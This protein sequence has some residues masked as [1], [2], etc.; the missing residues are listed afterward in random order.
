M[1]TDTLV[2]V[3]T[4][5]LMLC[6]SL[7]IPAIVVAAVTGLAVSF[8][9]AITSLQDQSISSAVKLVAVVVTLFATGAWASSSILR[10][11]NEIITLAIPS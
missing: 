7:S 11:A 9:Q 3:T 1:E 5:G 6:L 8:I 4:E 2:R 10:F